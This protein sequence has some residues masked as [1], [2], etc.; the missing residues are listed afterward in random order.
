MESERSST[1][2]SIGER[3]RSDRSNRRVVRGDEPADERND[4]AGDGG[5]DVDDR[6][7]PAEY[8][9]GD[10][11]RAERVDR[12]REKRRTAERCAKADRMAEALDLLDRFDRQEQR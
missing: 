5:R 10:G 4:D 2:R 11:E 6:P 8:R 12:E 1:R 9:D 3:T 7:N